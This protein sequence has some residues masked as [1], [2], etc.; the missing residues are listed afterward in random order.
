MP[1]TQLAT[2]NDAA[3]ASA[4]FTASGAKQYRQTVEDYATALA[5]RSA[6]LGEADKAPGL[7]AEI[8]HEHV[9][10]SAHSMARA[11]GS[12]QRSAWAVAGQ[13]GEYVATAVA[14]V[15]GGHL[16]KQAGIWTFGI[17]VSVAVVLVVARLAKGDK[18]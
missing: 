15:G 6:N 14:G 4:G 7:P 5:S 1:D 16:D 8:T 18:Q 9:R 12:G 2:I 3:L 10:A 17:A 11:F 13:V